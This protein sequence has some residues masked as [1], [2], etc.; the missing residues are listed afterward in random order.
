MALLFRNE[1][2]DQFAWPLGYIPYGGADFGEVKAVADAVGDGDDSAFHAA[3]TA[4]GD[5]LAAAAADALARGHR[6]SARA[7]FLKASAFHGASY[8]PLFGTPVDP[9]LI[10]SYRRQI[11]AF[12]AALA[13]SDPPVAPL[14]IPFGD[15]ILPARLIPASG[16]A[17]EVRPLIILTNGYDGTL[18]DLYFAS[19]V[20]ASRRGYHALIFDGPGQGGLLYDGG[21]PIRP[22]WETVIAAV[23]EFAVSESIV[24][25]GRIA[26][27]GWSLGGHLAARGASGEPRIAA[28]VADP[29]LYSIV[30]GIAAF[31]H[32]TFGVALAPGQKPSELDDATLAE[33]EAVIRRTPALRWSIVQRGFWVHGVATL[34]DYLRSAEAFTMDGWVDGIRCPTLFTMAEN[35]RLSAG[36]P[37]FFDALSCPKTLLRFTAAEGAGDH[38]EMKNRSLLNGRVFDWLDD[39]FAAA[40]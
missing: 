26:L 39:T 24:D 23:V 16:R 34:R 13:L 32:Q 29:G 17:R 8:H 21:V 3:W 5:R 6:E 4:A 30:S 11:A 18:T 28:L 10:E 33:V 40:R 1:L 7:L 38:C 37:A 36:T 12:D 35:D 31:L 2:H 22:D 19:A 14:A 9:R 20:A 15:I 25:P 27:S